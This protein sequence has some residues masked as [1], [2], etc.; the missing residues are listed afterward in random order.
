MPTRMGSFW[1]GSIREG[2]YSGRFPSDRS[3]SL[4]CPCRLKSKRDFIIKMIN[5]FLES[6]ITDLKKNVQRREI[7]FVPRHRIWWRQSS[8]RIAEFST[9]SCS[10][11]VVCMD[12]WN[13]NRTS[14]PRCIRCSWTRSYGGTRKICLTWARQHR[15]FHSRTWTLF[16]PHLS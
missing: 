15:T 1:F 9:W 16:P 2:Y 11:W 4:S 12:Y 13:G 10:S 6:C 8:F 14:S 7:V 5:S 3:S